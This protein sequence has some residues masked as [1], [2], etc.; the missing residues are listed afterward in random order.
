[1]LANSISKVN[2]GQVNEISPNRPRRQLTP[3]QES[4]FLNDLKMQLKGNTR[5][6]KHNGYIN[7]VPSFVT[8]NGDE[9]QLRHNGL[10]VK[11]QKTGVNYFVSLE[12]MSSCTSHKNARTAQEIAHKA[13]SMCYRADKLVKWFWGCRDRFPK[14]A[15][16]LKRQLESFCSP[17]YMRKFVT[18]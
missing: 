18:I 15:V 12:H 7:R 3:S 6:M 1:M 11:R 8:E 13:V 2:F 14:R 5:G 4:Q 9:L 16:Q 17:E 10:Y